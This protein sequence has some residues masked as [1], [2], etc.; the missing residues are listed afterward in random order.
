M[1]MPTGMPPPQ[2]GGMQPPGTQQ[3]L[4]GTSNEELIEAIIDEK[5]N[6]L[7]GDIN[8]LLDW[9]S[10]A[11]SEMAAM[12]QEISDLKGEFDRLHQG[13]VGKVGEYDKHILDVGAE[14]SAMEKVFAKVLPLFTEK[15]SEL[16][17]ISEDMKHS[18]GRK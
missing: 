14:I 16:S 13:V 2:M 10:Q 9:K 17:Q 8:K 18:L 15:V 5:W 12:K 1:N 3:G 7:L 11:E 4:S 6:E